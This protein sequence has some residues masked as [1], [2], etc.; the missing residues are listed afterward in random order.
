MNLPSQPARSVLRPC[1]LA[2]AVALLAG[3]QSIDMGSAQLRIVD[4]SR[5]SGALDLYQNGTGLAYNLGFGT[6][7]SYVAMSPGAYTLAAD[8]A[9]TRQ[10]LVEAST[11]LAAGRQYTA[12]VGNGLASLQQTILLDQSTPAPPGEIALRFVDQAPHAGAV[13]VY[14]VGAGGRLASTAPIATGLSFGAVQGYLNVP[15]GAYAIEVVPA[16]TAISTATATLLTG[17]Q[18]DYLSGAV[19]TVILLD[20][21]LP[22]THAPGIS[23]VVADDADAP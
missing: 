12:I 18:V 6:L 16:G 5:D 3:C 17:A 22:A 21:D 8:K 23:A 13:D 2:L 7:T 1:A 9:G 4:A 10:A 20:Q 15:A 14:L 19:R 11:H